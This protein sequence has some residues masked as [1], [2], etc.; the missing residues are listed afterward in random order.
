MKFSKLLAVLLA[1]CLL[2]TMM[3]ACDSGKPGEETTGEAATSVSISVT[4]IVKDAN[5]TEVANEVV[6]Y[7]GTNPTLGEIIESYC[8]M[9]DYPEAFDDLGLLSTIGELAP[10]GDQRWIAYYDSE[11]KSNAFDSIMNQPVADGQTVV[12]AID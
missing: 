12:V 2:G 10:T 5:G 8:A 11:G 6:A 7:T 3:I 1:I 4:L 9:M